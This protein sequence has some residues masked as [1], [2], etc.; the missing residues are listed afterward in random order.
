MSHDCCSPSNNTNH[1]AKKFDPFIVWTIVIT[2]VVLA[3]AVFFGSKIGATPQVSTDTKVALNVSSDTFDWGNIDYDGG[4]VSK[5]FPIKNESDA[6]LKLYNVKTSCMCTTAELKTPETTSRKFGMHETSTE[7]IEVKPQE[8]AELLV[9][10]DPAFHG[11]SGVGPITRTV[12]IDTN[13]SKHPNLTF[14]LSGTVV[15]K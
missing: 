1:G 8:T 6:T 10:F 4:I 9:E 14:N 2:V 5:S 3:G 11:P 12:T 13:D 15:K 7:V